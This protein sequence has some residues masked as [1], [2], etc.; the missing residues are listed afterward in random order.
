MVIRERET[1]GVP[2][3]VLSGKLDMFAKNSFMEAIGKQKEA[4]AKRVIIDMKGV[5]F[6]D[7][8]GLGVLAHAVKAFQT[9]KGSLIVVNP[10]D[11]VKSI[12]QNVNFS[13][14][15]PL[16]QTNEDYST[17]SELH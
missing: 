13:K 1:Q 10:Q 6:I 2:I 4:Q 11:A 9:I 12:L 14:L 5:P 3:L 8:A 7:S 15:L 16:F 17:F